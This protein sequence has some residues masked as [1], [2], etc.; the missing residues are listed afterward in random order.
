A[1]DRRGLVAPAV[2]LGFIARGCR[3]IEMLSRGQSRPQMRIAGEIARTRAARGPR[4]FR[5]PAHGLPAA[6]ATRLPFVPQIS[7]VAT[8]TKDASNTAVVVART[9][10]VINIHL[11]MRESSKAAL[12]PVL[13]A[14][15]NRIG[16]FS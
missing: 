12:S 15:R 13:A 11:V 4:S 5:R 7:P 6:F 2:R 1:G 3:L 16:C 8:A 10:A 9:V 14:R